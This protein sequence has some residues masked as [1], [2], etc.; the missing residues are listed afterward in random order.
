MYY[1]YRHIRSD[2]NQVFYIG[3]GKKLKPCRIFGPRTEF[4]RAFSK[5]KRSKFWQDIT[6]KTNY[7]V[8]ILFETDDMKGIIAKEIEFIKLYGRRDLKLGTLCNLTNGGHGIES[9][10]HSEE[11]KKRIGILSKTRV[12]KKG[13]K[14]NRTEEGRANIIKAIKSRVISKET[15]ERMSKGMLGNKRGLKK[16]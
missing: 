11:S 9:F 7:E 14:L 10:N 6:A 1:L 2:L 4:R 16:K 15:R 12:R 13:Y 8:E 5:A 3:I